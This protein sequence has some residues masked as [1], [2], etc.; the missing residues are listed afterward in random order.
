M[1][2]R[3]I[4]KNITHI[5]DRAKYAEMKLDEDLTNR[6]WFIEPIKSGKVYVS[7]FY[8][9]RFTGALC[10]TVSVPVRNEAD[11]IQ[12]VLG[13]DIRFEALAKMEQEGEI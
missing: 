8:T 13:L 4:T 7:D 12:G 2:G 11:D 5:I 1:D 6:P 3:K 9:S 10:I